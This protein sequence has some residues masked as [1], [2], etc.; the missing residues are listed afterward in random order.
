MK[1]VLSRRSFLRGAAAVGLAGSTGM[2]AE[3]CRGLP[4][5]KE[6]LGAVSANAAV[7]DEAYWDM[8]R[9]CFLL[10][11]EITHLNNGTLGPMPGFMV[12]GM[13]DRFTQLAR[14]PNCYHGSR[15]S[16]YDALEAVRKKTARFLH[17]APEEIAFPR[18][19][20]EGMSIIAGG[21]DMKPGEEV[22][23]TDHEH[24]GGLCCWQ[25]KAHREG[26]KVR[27]L[28]LPPVPES[29]EE[30]LERFEAAISPKTRLISVSHV[31]CTTGMRLPVQ[32]ICRMA[33]ERGILVCVDGAQTLGWMKVDLRDLECDFYTNS[34]HKWL[35]APMGTGVLFVKR[36]HIDR[37][38]PLV[39]SAGWDQEETAKK[40]EAIGTRNLPEAIAVGDAVD[41][42][43]AIGIERIEKRDYYLAGL[44]KEGFR[45]IDGV[46]LLSPVKEKVSSPLS[47]ILLR[48]KNGGEIPMDE[49][50]RAFFD[51]Y[52]I[53]V[54][55]VGEAGLNAFRFSSHVYN[56]PDCVEK[57]L[58]A[59]KDMADNG[60][61]GA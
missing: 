10:D 60:L 40:F 59:V 33:H 20:T 31:T 4:P 29:E 35:M 34:P 42:I 51:K 8:V 44:M 17:A 12:Q 30:I 18:N 55:R 9:R 32:A 14:D 41:F 3:S 52:R 1:S 48:R 57:G 58:A 11:P 6:A 15:P 23:T 53:R 16:M 21:L 5:R 24:A 13:C 47:T 39:I 25:C 50:Y 7:E 26:I 45:K 43:E 37:I 61:E 27:E 56:S 19:T 49:A 46:T 54:R 28:A 38:R 22:L 36:E 2:L